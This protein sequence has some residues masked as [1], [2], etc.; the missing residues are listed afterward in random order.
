MVDIHVPIRGFAQ[1]NTRTSLIVTVALQMD[2]QNKL[3]S[4]IY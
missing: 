4:W 1:T 2:I 3:Y